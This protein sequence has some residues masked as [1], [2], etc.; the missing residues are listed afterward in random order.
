[1]PIA[2]MW[3][4]DMMFL[5][6]QNPIFILPL[7]DLCCVY[8]IQSCAIITG[9]IYQNMTYGTT[10]TV[11][12]SESDI[13]ITTVTPYL[14]LSGEL[15]GIYCEDFGENWPHYNSTPLYYVMIYWTMRWKHWTVFVYVFMNF[16]VHHCLIFIFI[17][18]FNSSI[19]FC[20][21][22]FDQI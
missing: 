5:W 22:K 1:M 2:G 17:Y 11:A 21:N 15:W 9:P 8:L 13:I 10:I 3:G 6:I 19:H 14:A 12:E 7:I 20:M 4:L 18:Y 16:T